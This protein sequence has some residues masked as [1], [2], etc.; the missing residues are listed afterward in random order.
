M[1]APLLQQYQ[2]GIT[3]VSADGLNTFEQTCDTLSQL[4][5]FPG[6]A[7]MQVYSR[8]QNA[9]TD[10]GQGAFYWNANLTGATDD[11]FNTIV[12][13]GSTQ[14]AWVRI[15]FDGYTG[16]SSSLVTNTA[17][18]T[19]TTPANITSSTAFSFTLVG[20][21]G[22]GGGASATANYVGA[23]GGAGGVS[24]VTT[25]GLAASTSYTIAVGTAGQG[26]AS[27]ANA[28][29]SG[30]ATTLTI[31]TTTYTAA[32]GLGGA[33]GSSITPKVTAGGSVTNGTIQIPGQS[34]IT[35]GNLAAGG[36]YSQGGSGM[37]GSAA[38]AAIVS[39]T[40]A[41][42]VNATGYGAGGTGGYAGTGTAEA[43]GNGTQGFF[44]ATWSI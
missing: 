35:I 27:G 9:L 12:P 31:G 13:Y 11:N 26:G 32:G 39:G 23:P 38:V 4:R 33:A 43:G 18:V 42:G 44:L 34:G 17:T 16:N 14:G 36:G 22:G 37:Y 5:A 7:G 25:S 29:T 41:A 3:V 15:S 10:G 40:A 19:F 28:G 20:A 21:G 1:S 6:T 24:L 2:Q 30:G 8:G